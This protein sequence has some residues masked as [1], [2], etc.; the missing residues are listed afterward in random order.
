V[1]SKLDFPQK[2]GFKKLSLYLVLRSAVNVVLLQVP[3]QLEPNSLASLQPHRRT[4]AI[5]ESYGVPSS[6]VTHAV[7]SSASSEHEVA[8]AGKTSRDLFRQFG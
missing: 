5:T 7:F 6:A 2:Q 3:G 8:L 1:A 4:L